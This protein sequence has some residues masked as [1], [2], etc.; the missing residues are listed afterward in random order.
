M[1]F[2]DALALIQSK[3]RKKVMSD[4]MKGRSPWNKGQKMPEDSCKKMSEKRKQRKKQP[5]EGK[6]LSE[7]QIQRLRE[8]QAGCKSHW[9]KGGI[10]FEPY[11][12]KFNKGFRERVRAFF[13]YRCQMCGQVWQKGETRLAVHHVTFDKQSCCNRSIPLFVPL[14]LSCH[15][16]TQTNREFWEDWF[17]EIINEFY[18]GQCYLPKI[19]N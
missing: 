15:A 17:T 16:K 3:E 18:G 14:C 12:P 1:K 7:T 19:N 5:M 13:G 4:T 8:Q 11:C 6:K 9:W 2:S 10:S